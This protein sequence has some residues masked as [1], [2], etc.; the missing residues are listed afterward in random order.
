MGQLESFGESGTPANEKALEVVAQLINEVQPGAMV[1]K[2]VLMVETIDQDDRWLSSFTAP[3]QKAWDT[4]GM[5]KYGLAYE[6]NFE[7]SSEQIGDDDG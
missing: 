5:L 4:M 1:Q 7:A 3:G 6:S 2:F